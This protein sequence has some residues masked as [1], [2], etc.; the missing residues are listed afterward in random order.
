[1]TSVIKKYSTKMIRVICFFVTFAAR[2]RFRS[3]RV[4][5]LEDAF[6]VYS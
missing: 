3:R 2:Y 6:Q 1:M 4:E 5:V